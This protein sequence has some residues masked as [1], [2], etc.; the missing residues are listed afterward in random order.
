MLIAVHVSKTAGASFRLWLEGVYGAENIF[1]DYVD[2]LT[3]PSS[4]MHRDRAC[5]LAEAARRPAPPGKNV[6]YGH[7]WIKKYEHLP[8]QRIAFL[9]EP[10]DRAMSHYF[11]WKK[12]TPPRHSFHEQVKAPDF[13]FERFIAH[14]FIARFY[15]GLWFADVRMKDFTF[16]G[17]F[18]RH[19]SEMDRLER[20]L[21]RSGPR[22]AKN[23]NPHAGYA[24]QRTRLIED[25]RLMAKARE[26]MADDIRFYERH[27]GR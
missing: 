12:L 13:S 9:R 20:V 2:K 15:T 21:G 27:A 6:I 7:F 24:E 19:E 10:I 3:D 22:V 18:A 4:P 17:D 14:P 23:A 26:L 5:F 8:G 1:R 16:I 25:S 11:F